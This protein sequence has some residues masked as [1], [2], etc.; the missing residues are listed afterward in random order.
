MKHADAFAVDV[1]EG[2]VIELLEY[3]VTGV[4]EDVAARMVADALQKHL[5][6]DTVVQVFAGVELEA[7]VDA[8]LVVKIEDGLPAARELGECGI[9]EAGGTLRPGIEIGP[10]ECAGEGADFGEAET[11][12]GPRGKLELRDG[13]RRACA[14]VAADCRRS[15]GVEQIVI[16]G[17]RG[18]ELAEHVRR[19]LG[20]DEAV[21]GECAGEFVAVGLTLGGASEIDEA[22]VPCGDLQGAKAEPGGP[23]RDCGKRVEGRLIA[24]ELREMDRWPLKSFHGARDSSK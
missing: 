20:D 5:E 14:F 19:Q 21:F 2:E 6:G 11:A 8:L 3:E 4:V 15:E 24:A 22:R 1:E 10:R 7:E 9:D 13:P 16:G 18:D 17:V 23:L 12:R